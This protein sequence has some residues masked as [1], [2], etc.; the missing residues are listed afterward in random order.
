[1]IVVPATPEAHQPP[2]TAKQRAK[3]DEAAEL[4]ITTDSGLDAA[5]Q[6]G[7]C[8]G[9]SLPFV[10]IGTEPTNVVAYV[11]RQINHSCRKMS[12]MDDI[13]S[14][15]LV[16]NAV[17]KDP[18]FV[19]VVIVVIDHIGNGAEVVLDYRKVVCERSTTHEHEI[20]LVVKRV[21]AELGFCL[22]ES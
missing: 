21:F 7:P 20:L 18:R 4:T 2:P 11:V 22:T 13:C 15:K 1:V 8:V 3:P 14:L 17:R 6:F 16:S 19:I 5:N 9:H 12:N 10:V